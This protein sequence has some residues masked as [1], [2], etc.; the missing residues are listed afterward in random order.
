MGMVPE[1]AVAMLACARIGAPHS[2]VFGGFS[3]DSLRDRINDA[4]ATVLVSADGAWRRGSV[5][6]SRDRDEAGRQRPRSP[7]WF[8]APHRP[9]FR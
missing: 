5:V 6:P 8:A 1:I 3:A 9:H 4:Q 2:V 7:P